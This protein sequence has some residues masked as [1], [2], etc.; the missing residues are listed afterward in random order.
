MKLILNQVDSTNLYKKIKLLK[1]GIILLIM[2]IL[3]IF[4]AEA[5]AHAQCELN[6]I[7]IIPD[8]NRRWAKENNLDSLEGHKEG[9]IN[10]TPKV[11]EDLWN[12]G[13]HTVTI[14]GVSTENWKR[15]EKEVANIMECID[16][17]LKKMLPIA[18]NSKAKIIHIGRKDRLPAYLLKTLMFV[19]NET[20]SFDE[21]IFNFAIDFGGRDEIV[22]ACQKTQKLKGSLDDITEEDISA[23]MDTAQQPFPLPD[24]IVRTSGEMRLSGF[25]AWQAIYSELYFT[26]KYY[27]ALTRNDLEEAVESFNHRQR[28]YGK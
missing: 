5:Y 18:K 22:R 4:K 20:S 14:W 3:I 24:L 19:E 25:M 2:I 28:N 7:A 26:K 15:S 6:H 1:N 11:I 21:H 13:I 8:G 17:L 23:A 9:F 12:M 10:T 27:P 16:L